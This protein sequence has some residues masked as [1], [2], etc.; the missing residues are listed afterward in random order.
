MKIKNIKPG[1]ELL[2]IEG[3]LNGK[4][5]IVGSVHPRGLPS[6]AGTQSPPCVLVHPVDDPRIKFAVGPWML[7]K[8]N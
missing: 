8:P 1:E 6:L 4:R 2:V 7:G 5:V 3:V